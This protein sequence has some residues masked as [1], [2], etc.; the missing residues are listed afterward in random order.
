MYLLNEIDLLHY[1]HNELLRE[2]ERVRLARRLRSAHP[3][4]AARIWNAIR[5]RFRDRVPGA[6][7][8]LRA[9]DSRCA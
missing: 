2:A 9:G 3:K 4:R 1:R 8:D 5:D 6:P 7:G